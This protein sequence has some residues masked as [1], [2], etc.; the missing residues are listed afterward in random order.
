MRLYGHKKIYPVTTHA[1]PV[2]QKSIRSKITSI[3][4]KNP[5]YKEHSNARLNVIAF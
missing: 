2:T 4:S 1:Y 5:I 3:R